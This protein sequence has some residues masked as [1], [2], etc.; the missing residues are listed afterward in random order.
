MPTDE[1]K[2]RIE[3]Y[4]L[5]AARNAGVPIP[6]GEKAGLEPAP[7]F[8]FENDGL[9]V[10]LT[11][12]TRPADDEGGFVPTAEEAFH[13]ELVKAAQEQHYSAPD[14]KPCRLVVYFPIGSGKKRDKRKMAR[15]LS[16][17][18][19]ANVHRA[20]PVAGF[21]TLETPDGIGAMSITSEG[22]D[23]WS[24]ECGRT[25]LSQIRAQLAYRI[26]D[27]NKRV[28]QYRKGLPE[29]YSVWLLIY[30]GVA[31]SRNMPIPHDI[32]GW[33]FPFEFDKVFWFDCLE[34]RFAEITRARAA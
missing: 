24:G 2:K 8:I 3:V 32:E 33:S 17:F 5:A 19:K 14:T 6:T 28:E 20:N 10:E 12:L 18:V 27:K 22:G 15:A 23:W 7:D 34:G 31:V 11:E 4:M 16:D 26:G 1:E 9:G 13:R 21:S 29:G 25:T 30:S